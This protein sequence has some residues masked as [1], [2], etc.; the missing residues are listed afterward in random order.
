MNRAVKNTFKSISYNFSARA[1][2]LRDRIAA[3]PGP[4]NGKGLALGFLA[5][6]AEAG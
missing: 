3:G 2:R 4:G 6:T 5:L 1:V